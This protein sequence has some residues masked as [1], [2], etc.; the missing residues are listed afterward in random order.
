MSKKSRKHASQTQAQT[1][2]KPKPSADPPGKGV[3]SPEFK[4]FFG[5]YK[6]RKDYVD[7]LEYQI[8]IRNEWG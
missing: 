6:N 2:Q 4:A 7:G 3:N 1:A 5:L 8:K